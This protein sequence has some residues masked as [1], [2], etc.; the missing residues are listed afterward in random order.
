M[1][2][3]LALGMSR[4]LSMIVV[5]SSISNLWSTKPSI[6]SSSSPFGI[7]PWPMSSVR[8]GHDLLQPSGDDLDVVTRLWTKKICPSRFSSR[9][10]AWRISSASNRVT[11]VSTASRSSGGVSRLRDV[12]QAQQ[13]H[14]QRARDRRGRQRQHV[15]GLPQ[16][17]EPLLDLD[18]EP[19]LL[20]DDHQAQVVELHVGL[21][22]AVR[23]DDD[24]E[25]PPAAAAPGCAS[26]AALRAEAA[27]RGDLERDTRPSAR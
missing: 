9:S 3:V 5:A 16:R 25:R 17:L 27:E 12:A 22:E 18:A 13:R 14:V 2:I 4:P 24:V 8:L 7:W 1:K 19:L 11:R 10:T 15:D 6:T 21:H 26:A 23:A 20:V